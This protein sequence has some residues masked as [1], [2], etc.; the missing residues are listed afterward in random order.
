MRR[1]NVHPSGPEIFIASVRPCKALS[2]PLTWGK[3]ISWRVTALSSW[4]LSFTMNFSGHITRTISVLVYWGFGVDCY[5]SII[6]SPLYYR[7]LCL[8]YLALITHLHSVPDLSFGKITPVPGFNDRV[9][10]EK[11]WKCRL[12]R[13][14]YFVHYLILLKGKHLN[15]I[16][17]WKMVIWKGYTLQDSNYTT[18]WKSKVMEKVKGSLVVR[19]W[20]K[21]E[22]NRW[23]TDFL[24][25]WKYSVWYYNGGYMSLYIS[26]K[27]HRMYKTEWTLI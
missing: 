4:L 5:C 27:T 23:S 2:F 11:K 24:G 15:V 14:A 20:G 19:G 7:S 12:N 25:H 18:F 21:G 22:T 6:N 17:R 13:K 16:V 8:S 1:G 9:E 26:V 10:A 3:A